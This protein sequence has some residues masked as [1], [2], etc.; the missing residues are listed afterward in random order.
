MAYAHIV[1]RTDD[2]KGLDE[3]LY[4][5]VDGWEAADARLWEVLDS[6]PTERDG[7]A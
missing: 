1:S 2:R 4:A 7:A 6:R 3:E 5:P